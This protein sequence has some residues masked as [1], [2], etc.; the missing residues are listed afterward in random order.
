MHLLIQLIFGYLFADFIM[1]IYHWIKDSYFSPLTPIIGKRF[2]WG[3]RLHHI[4]ARYILEVSNWEI[5][6][7]SALWTTW[8]FPIIYYSNYRY[9]FISSYIVISLNDIFHKYVHLLDY[10]RPYFFTLLQR[11]LIVQSYDEH[12]IHHLGDHDSNYC[13]ITPYVNF[14]LERINFWRNLEFIILT[15]TG[16]QA[17]ASRDNYV[18]DRQYKGGIKFV[19]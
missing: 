14:I 12:K 19:P 2:V 1:G 6:K 18:V 16:V 3:S 15:L 7:D 8:L 13:P 17:R 10:E 11:L 5:L 4:K 9:F